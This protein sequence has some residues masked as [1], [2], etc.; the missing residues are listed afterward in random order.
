ML[1]ASI[2]SVNASAVITGATFLVPALGVAIALLCC[3]LFFIFFY[4]NGTFRS[5]HA[6]TAVLCHH[7]K[8]LPGSGVSCWQSTKGKYVLKL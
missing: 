7:Y 4:L 2:Q 3:F 1:N 6:H 8:K 5:P